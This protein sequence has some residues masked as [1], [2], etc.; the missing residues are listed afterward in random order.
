MPRLRRRSRRPGGGGTLRGIVAG[1]GCPGCPAA[2]HR[3]VAHHDR[4]RRV[5]HT[6]TRAERLTGNVAATLTGRDNDHG[7]NHN[8]GRCSTFCCESARLPGSGVGGHWRCRGSPRSQRVGHGTVGTVRG[9]RR[10]VRRRGTRLHFSQPRPHQLRRAHDDNRRDHRGVP[11]RRL[12]LR[13]QRPAVFCGIG[14]GPR[15]CLRAARRLGHLPTGTSR[16]E[17]LRVRQRRHP[18][19]LRGTH[20][21]RVAR[22]GAH[23]GVDIRRRS[24][25]HARPVRSSRGQPV[26]RGARKPVCG[27]HRAWT[28]PARSAPRPAL[29]HGARRG[30]RHGP[31]H[32]SRSGCGLTGAARGDRCCARRGAGL[33]DSRHSGLPRGRRGSR[34][35]KR[36]PPVLEL[37]GGRPRGRRGGA[38]APRPDTT[39]RRMVSG[40]AS[41]L[42]RGSAR[43]RHGA[44]QHGHRTPG[45]PPGGGRFRGAGRRRSRAL[46]RRTSA[47]LSH[48]YPHGWRRLTRPRLGDRVAD[49][50]SGDTRRS[51]GGRR[52]TV[53][54]VR[55]VTVSVG[56]VGS[57]TDGSS[58][59]GSSA[60]GAG[61]CGSS[62][63]APARPGAGGADACVADHDGLERVRSARAGD[64]GSSARRH[65]ERGAHSCAPHYTGPGIAARSP[66]CG[67]PPA[68]RAGRDG[69]LDSARDDRLGWRRGGARAGRRGPHPAGSGTPVVFRRRIRLRAGRLRERTRSGPGREHRGAVPHDDPR[70]AVRSHHDAHHV[71]V[72]AQLVRRTHRD[73]G[74]LSDRGRGRADRTQRLDR[75]VHRCRVCARPDASGHPAPG[76]DSAVA[77]YSCGAAR[78]GA[79][80]SGRLSRRPAADERIAD[81]AADR[82]RDRGRHHSSGPPDRQRSHQIG[83]FHCRSGCRPV[84]D[85]NRRRRHGG[86]GGSARSGA[87]CRRTRDNVPRARHPR[88]RSRRQ[89]PHHPPPLCLVGRRCVLDRCAVVRLGS[90]GRKRS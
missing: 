34:Q 68:A 2:H 1:S 45:R 17:P 41:A 54:A 49:P 70:P 4:P 75:A 82:G 50:R 26:V 88:R 76:Y 24:G 61:R 14:G 55:G 21:Y 15:R 16:R 81:R 42:R 69:R 32:S 9:R 18:R 10:A 6:G 66:C 36:A 3:P 29:R 33:R 62:R 89:R 73:L 78:T 79:C 90:A 35:Q 47:R 72:P 27:R 56:T 57:S 28:V 60:V 13:P 48:L 84:L 63:P 11:R 87:G 43:G 20:V 80:R 8:T 25:P 51:R 44:Q 77:I 64:S 59:D 65:P 5:A 22:P 30:T 38:P 83:H 52:D 46:H 53:G 31:G 19:H 37:H 85:R 74:A 39:P 12:V 71:A 67:R 23:V 58:T 7:H 40:A 86:A